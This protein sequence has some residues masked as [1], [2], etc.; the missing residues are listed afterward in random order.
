MIKFR[1]NK[2]PAFSSGDKINVSAVFD[3]YSGRED[4]C[5]VFIGDHKISILLKE[6]FLTKVET[7][8]SQA[9]QAEVCQKPHKEPRDYS[10][11]LFLLVVFSFAAGIYGF[12]QIPKRPENLNSEIMTG[13]MVTSVTQMTNH[14]FFAT[15]N[16]KAGK[17]DVEIKDALPNFDFKPVVSH[18]E[19]GNAPISYFFVIVSSVFLLSAPVWLFLYIA[20]TKTY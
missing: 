8:Q 6:N 18:E 10:W 17:F 19:Y 11:C 5:Y 4:L 3:S 15:M 14:K 2:K 13:Y 12:V 20:N 16:G 1:K 9:G 7:P